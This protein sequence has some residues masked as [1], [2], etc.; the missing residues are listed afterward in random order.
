MLMLHI[1]KQDAALQVDS[2]QQKLLLQALIYVMEQPDVHS[3]MKSG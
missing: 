2:L 1:N 3:S